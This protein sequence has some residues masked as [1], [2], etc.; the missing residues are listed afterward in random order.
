MKLVIFEPE[1]IHNFYPVAYLRPTFEL[2]C[3]HSLLYEKI[4]RNHP[5]LPVSFFCR[6]CLAETFACRAPEGSTVND[7]AGLEDDLLVINGCIL[8]GGWKLERDGGEE[9]GV[10]PQGELLYARISRQSAASLP[11]ENIHSF[12]AA[13]VEKLPKKTNENLTLIRDQ[14]ELIHSNPAAI[15][16][17]FGIAGKS[18]VEGIT[19]QS[20][21]KERSHLFWVGG[22]E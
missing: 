21:S 12:L 4:M 2:R 10:S 14:W 11:R 6:D 8:S 5:G 16:S 18:G 1:N 15:V 20:A 22:W 7:P 9:A 13:A 17:D 19:P 3:G